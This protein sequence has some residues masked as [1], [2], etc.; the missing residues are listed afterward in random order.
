V[1]FAP[2][3]VSAGTSS[4][5]SDET[6]YLA[7]GPPAVGSNGSYSV[8]TTYGTPFSLPGISAGTQ[9]PSGTYTIGANTAGCTVGANGS[10]FAYTHVGSC[11]IT[12]VATGDPDDSSNGGNSDGHEGSGNDPDTASATLTVTVN[13]GKQ[14]ISVTPQSGSVGATLPLVATG[15]LGTGAITFS[16]VGG[17]TAPGCALSGPSGVKSTGAG[18]CLV[19][20]TIAADSDFASATSAPATMSFL[21]QSQTITVVAKSGTVGVPLALSATGYSGTGAITFAI[22]SGGTA[23]G[24]AVNSTQHLTVTG[25]GTCQVTATIAADGSYLSATSAPGTMTMVNPPIRFVLHVTASSE[26]VAA[27]DPVNETSSVTGVMSGDSAHLNSVSYTYTGTG[28]TNYGPS[29]TVPQG[30]GTYSV[31]PSHAS[32]TIS[33]SADQAHYTQ[34]LYNSGTLTITG[35]KLTVTATGGSV[36]AGKPFHPGATVSDLLTGDSASVTSATYTYTGTAGT[37]YGPSTRAPSAAGAY[38]VTPS[39]ASV[40]VTPSGH[41]GYYTEP[42]KYVAGTLVITPKP[43]VIQVSPPQIKTVTIKPFAE[44]SYALSKKLLKQVHR[45]ALQVKNGKYHA[46][47]LQAYTDNVFT[48]AFNTL[49]NQNRAEAVSR[50]LAKDLKALKDTAVTI[51][52]VTGIS[53]ILVSSNS[54]AKGRAANRRVV[55][56]LK[57]T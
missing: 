41:Q 8:S 39:N 31:T 9:T 50:Q 18:T 20:A 14:T 13:P 24:C 7:F 32:I 15:Y 25:P 29:A 53:I 51:T 16:V 38:T 2:I 56:T 49:L 6:D 12:V 10:G 36:E 42:Y 35:A 47:Q 26:T 54:S 34:I 1:S 4:A 21:K 3:V 45:L 11:S 55:A 27:G 28:T 33:P 52:I 48:A 5:S 57:A 43:I 46:V 40:S 19:T 23:S 44:G 30:A 17:G 22:V 37:T